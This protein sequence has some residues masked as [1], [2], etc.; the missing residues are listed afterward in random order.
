MAELQARQDAEH[1]LVAQVERALK[2][3]DEEA[4]VGCSFCLLFRRLR[5]FKPLSATK[6]AQSDGATAAAAT[7]SGKTDGATSTR[8]AIFGKKKKADP[9]AKL[10]EAAHAMGERIRA[11]EYRE[12]EGKE[13]AKRLAQQ[14]QKAAALRALR[15]AKTLAK[16][17]EQNQAALD[18]V[19]AQIDM[20]AQAEVQKQ[21]STALTTSS[22][23]LK[24]Q[25]QILKN[26]ESAIDAAQDARD[27]ADDLNGV[28]AEFAG[29]TAAHDDDELLQELDELIAAAKPPAPPPPE[30]TMVDPQLKEIERLEKRHREYDEAKQ[31]RA[32]FPNAGNRRVTEEKT[33]L[34]EAVGV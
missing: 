3:V 31:L 25:K 21:L 1:E 29:G 18:A 4:D 10:Q 11:L 14:G 32:S 7:A 28:I 22:A 19:D 12:I 5:G 23:G 13:E 30:E 6:L 34:M 20:L 24:G 26:A 33:R 8:A 2:I 17:V 27:T 15:K 16:Q 9:A